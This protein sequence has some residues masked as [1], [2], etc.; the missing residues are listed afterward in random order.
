MTFE[1]A[2]SSAKRTQR[3][4]KG[5]VEMRRANA[6]D[7]KEPSLW[8]SMCWQKLP[9]A[10]QIDIKR[11]RKGR[12]AKV[13][14]SRLRNQT[15]A[16]THR[17]ILLTPVNRSH[18]TRTNLQAT[19]T[20]TQEISHG[21]YARSVRRSKSKYL[22]LAPGYPVFKTTQAFRGITGSLTLPPQGAN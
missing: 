22:S 7:G 13:Y 11:R 21:S 15:K 2:K 3:R 9:K 4:T 18:T 10:S 1:L 16:Q 8:A 12:N 19:S 17:S 20:H 6:P 5:S 14:Y